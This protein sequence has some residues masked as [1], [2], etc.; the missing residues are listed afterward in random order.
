MILLL[1]ALGAILWLA[2]GIFTV[3]PR[4]QAALRLFGD[5]QQTRS[6]GLHWWWPSPIGKSDIVDVG[7]TRNMDLGFFTSPNGVTADQDAEALM[8]TGD[9]NIVNVQMVVQYKISDLGK[10]LFRVD[11]PG[12]DLR[13]IGLGNPEGRTLKDATESALRQVVG[14]RSIDDSL[15]ERREEVQADTQELLQGILDSYDTG[16]LVLD[17]VLQTTRPPDEVRAAFDDVVS[18]RVDQQSRINEANAYEQ[19][20]LPRVKGEAQQ[21]VQAAEAFKA[22]RIARATGEASRFLSVL[23]EYTESKEVTRQRLWL[24]AIEEILPG[25]TKYILTSDSGGNLLQFLPL[26]GDGG[27]TP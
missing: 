23:E 11:D 5:F 2:S 18:A 19:D 6:S 1:V 10:F 27:T 12:E 15:V 20:K 13:G 22:E 3:G 16:I 8:I 25:V 4:E 26:D 21:I 17:V 7:A 14:Q 24:E 9:L